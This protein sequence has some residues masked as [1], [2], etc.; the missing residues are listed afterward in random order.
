MPEPTP[1][2]RKRLTIDLSDPEHRVLKGC[3]A[4]AGVTMRVFVL[5]I[6]RREGVLSR[7]KEID[8]SDT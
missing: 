7:T 8:V 1:L 4:E 2:K 5:K 3:A 6:L